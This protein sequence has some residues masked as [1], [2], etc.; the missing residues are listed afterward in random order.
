MIRPLATLLLLGGLLLGASGS[1]ACNKAADA[2]PKPDP[3][4][5]TWRQLSMTLADSSLTRVAVLRVD[6]KVTHS[7]DV[8]RQVQ[9][10]MLA[11]LTQF[12]DVDFV[13]AD[14][15]VVASTLAKHNTDPASGIAPTIATE[16][17]GI[18]GVDG[19]IYATVEN[20][21]YD[22]NVKVYVANPGNVIFSK[23]LQDVALPSSEPKDEQAGEKSAPAP[24]A[25]ALKV[26][27]STETTAAK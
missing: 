18:L 17:C 13:E 4:K 26:E 25:K 19:F 15:D 21:D 1:L 24:A 3:N 22:V 11:E 23:T 7:T 20:G 10:S 5:N 16:L 8:E 6:D 14:R 9:E 27:P 2:A 12:P